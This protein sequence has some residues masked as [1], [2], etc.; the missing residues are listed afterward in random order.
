M[1]AAL[2]DETPGVVLAIYAHPDDAEVAAGGTLA[3]WASSGAAVYVCVCAQG[4]KGS[5]DP[6]VV[7]ATLVESRKFESAKASEILGLDGR[8]WLG[9]SDGEFENTAQLRAQLVGLIRK[10]KPHVVLAPDPTAVFF[11][12]TYVNHRDHRVVGWAVIDA[13]CPAASNPHYFPGEGPPY[14]VS[15]LFLSGTL[16]PDVWVDVTDS[17]DAKVSAVI[18]HASQIGERRD[19]VRSSVLRRASDAGHR[20]GTR[21]AE[22]FRQVVLW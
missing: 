22:G 2:L 21:F 5:L 7:P 6:L 13:V 8:Y 14:A 12:Q 4:D 17:I 19:L 3:R 11:G 18:C 16:E 1:P 20:A 9:H 10:L 15:K